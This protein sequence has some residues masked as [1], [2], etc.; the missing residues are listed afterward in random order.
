MR[1]DLEKGPVWEGSI[2]RSHHL[3]IPTGQTIG[4]LMY[5]SG[6]TGKPEGVMLSHTNLIAAG[7]YIS[8]GHAIPRDDRALCVLRF[9][10]L[11]VSASP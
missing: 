9:I 2:Q 1:L 8:S 10:I 5:T 4:L 3:S 11:T 6:T 7:R